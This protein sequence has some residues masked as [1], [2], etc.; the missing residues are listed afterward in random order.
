MAIE[1]LDRNKKY[2]KGKKK[3]GMVAVKVVVP[4]TKRG[5]VIGLAK[6]WREEIKK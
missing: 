3:Q 5:V 4:Q 1:Q 2:L 6:Q